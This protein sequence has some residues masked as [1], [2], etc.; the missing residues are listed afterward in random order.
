MKL[1][2]QLMNGCLSPLSRFALTCDPFTLAAASMGMSAGQA[3]MDIYGQFVQRDTHKAQEE[4]RRIETENAIEENRRRATHDYLT[5]TRLERTQEAQEHASLAQKKMDVF[6]QTDATIATSIAS[7]AERNV[8]G[9]TVDMIASDFEFMADEE[10][11][12][13]KQNQKL[14]DRQHTENI[15][16]QGTEWQNRVTSIKPYIKTP[17]PQ[18]DFF[19]PVFK[20]VGQGIQTIGT[21]AL[22]GSGFGAQASNMPNPGAQKLR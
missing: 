1:S 18:I 8:A 9:R 20:A 5:A 15:R 3:G 17:A 19:G 7:A 13:L 14:A 10:T 11:G 12:R 4:A 22:T 2:D 16:A 6:R 21:G